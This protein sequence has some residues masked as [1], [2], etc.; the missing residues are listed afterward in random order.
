VPQ[1]GM[2]YDYLFD[3]Q[4]FGARPLRRTGDCLFGGSIERL[5]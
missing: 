1:Q 4:V 5:R 2:V 3:N